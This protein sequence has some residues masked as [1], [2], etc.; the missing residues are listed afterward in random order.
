[1]EPELARP[2][3]LDPAHGPQLGHVPLAPEVLELRV[4]GTG[5]EGAGDEVVVAVAVH[6]RPGRGGPRA[7]RSL[8][9]PAILARCLLNMGLLDSAQKQ[10]EEAARHLEEALQVAQSVDM[11]VLQERIRAALAALPSEGSPSAA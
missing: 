8:G 7:T 3:L 4:L 9:V 10:H 2:H 1:V 5:E 6:P 11:H